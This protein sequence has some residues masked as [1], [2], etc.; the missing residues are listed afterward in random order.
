MIECGQNGLIKLINCTSTSNQYGAL[1]NSRNTTYL[2][3]SNGHR[4]YMTLTV[5]DHVNGFV[6]TLSGP[7]ALAP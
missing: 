5:T 4:K 3:D 1:I 2:Q 7:N 6:M